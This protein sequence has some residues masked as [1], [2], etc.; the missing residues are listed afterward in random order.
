MI[1]FTSVFHQY[2]NGPGISFPD[3]KLERGEQLLVLGP[4]GSGKSTLLNILAGIMKPTQGSYSLDGKEMATMS[5]T[6]LDAFRGEKI[7]M[8][9][10]RPHLIDVL[11]VEENLLLA[12]YMAGKGQKLSR[13]HELLE[14][15]ELSEKRRAKIS[16]ISE[17]QKQ[18]VSIA[19]ALMNEPALLLADEPT[20]ALD[21]QRA[22][23]VTDML[24]SLSREQNAALIISTHDQRIRSKI[25]RV[26]QIEEG[27]GSANL[28]SSKLAQEVSR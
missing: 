4:S 5:Q 2:A 13:A 25:S 7:G 15:L 21:D 18:R 17:G 23:I 19:R 24:I 20:S 27:L 22:A 10:Q 1:S 11:T 6:Q 8:I 28:Q 14:K 16:E 12:N 9:F 26:V 3:F